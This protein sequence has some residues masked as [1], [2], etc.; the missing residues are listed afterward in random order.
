MITRTVTI[1]ALLLL[2]FSAF[3]QTETAPAAPTVKAFGGRVTGEEHLTAVIE[4]VKAET[5][6]VTLR[7]SSGEAFTFV[8]GPDVRNFAQIKV[9]DKVDLVTAVELTVIVTNVAREPERTDSV[10]IARAPEGGKPGMVV[11][12]RSKGSAVIEAIDYAKRTAKLRGPKRTVE[13]EASA[14]AK[15]F[16]EAKV[17]DT[18]MI[19]Y[20][21]TTLISVHTP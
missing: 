6:E 2:P 5:R 16:N 19:D 11:V 9:G 18:V 13:I 7:E 10:E 4:A 14:E 1:A 17:G 12:Q 15:N 8:A 3:A 21:E 20:I